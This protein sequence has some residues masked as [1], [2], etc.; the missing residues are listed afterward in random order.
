M[1]SLDDHANKLP[2]EGGGLDCPVS[3]ITIHGAIF[4]ESGGRGQEWLS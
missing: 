2:S 4:I 3:E 1:F